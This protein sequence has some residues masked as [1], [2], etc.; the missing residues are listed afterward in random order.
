MSN[1]DSFR[2]SKKAA[3]P[4]S[5]FSID[6]SLTLISVLLNSLTLFSSS[7]KLDNCF[8]FC[9]YKSEKIFFPN[10]LSSDIIFQAL[11]SSWFSSSKSSTHFNTLFLGS[12]SSINLSTALSFTC[13]SL[14]VTRSLAVKSN[15]RAKLFKTP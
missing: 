15:S 10:D 5:S 7:K 8:S 14:R 6:S 13:S 12:S 1:P 4:L 3:T 9:L 11:F 2:M